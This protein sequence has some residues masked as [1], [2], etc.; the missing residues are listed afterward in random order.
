M[1][2]YDGYSIE[3]GIEKHGKGELSSSAEVDKYG[4]EEKVQRGGRKLLYLSKRAANQVF[5]VK[6]YTDRNLWQKNGPICTKARNANLS[7]LDE[8]IKHFE[9]SLSNRP[10]GGDS[11]HDFMRERIEECVQE[12]RQCRSEREGMCKLA[13]RMGAMNM[14]DD[15]FPA[16]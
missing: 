4:L 13:D 7:K 8:A 16:L 2:D 11:G 9:V 5:G 6:S 12:L 14:T 10:K 3:S 15:Q 1:L